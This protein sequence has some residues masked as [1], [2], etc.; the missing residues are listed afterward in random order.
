MLN[1]IFW[2]YN[3]GL[4]NPS[5][6]YLETSLSFSYRDSSINDIE[7]FNGVRSS[8]ETDDINYDLCSLI[9]SRY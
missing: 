3:A 2:L 9:S 1:S 8:C 7:L 5:L 6:T 4:S